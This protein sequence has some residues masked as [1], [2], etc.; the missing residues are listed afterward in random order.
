MKS[1]ISLVLTGRSKRLMR[2]EVKLSAEPSNEAVLIEVSIG[3]DHVDMDEC[4]DII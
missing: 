2:V 3:A 1:R 4:I